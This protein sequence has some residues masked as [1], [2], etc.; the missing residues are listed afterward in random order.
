MACASILG[1][2]SHAFDLNW[3]KAVSVP[4]TVLHRVDFPDDYNFD[5]A[6]VADARIMGLRL[7]EVVVKNGFPAELAGVSAGLVSTSKSCGTFRSCTVYPRSCS[8]SFYSVDS[9]VTFALM[10]LEPRYGRDAENCQVDAT[11]LESNPQ[12]IFAHIEPVS[13]YIYK[14]CQVE[15]L[16]V[17]F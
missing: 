10:K 5:R 4:W 8:L 9:H 13:G 11:A 1:L 16:K 14:G 3:P 12:I 7:S 2:T 17:M 6:C 15:F